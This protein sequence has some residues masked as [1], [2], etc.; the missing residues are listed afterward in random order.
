M[1]ARE[2]SWKGLSRLWVVISGVAEDTDSRTPES[3][4]IAGVYPSTVLLVVALENSSNLN[5][6]TIQA[7]GPIFS[8]GSNL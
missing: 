4:P 5:A 6:E 7:S 8:D 1:Q 2:S 3:C